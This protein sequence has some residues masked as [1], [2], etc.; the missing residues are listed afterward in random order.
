MSDF[1]KT[2]TRKNSLRKQCQ[3]LEVAD[4]EKIVA[5]LATIIDEKVQQELAV[6][7]EAEEKAAKIDE[8]RKSLDAAGLDLSDLMAIPEL[9]SKKKVAAKYRLTDESG[10]VHEWS[11]RGR[12]PLVFQKFFDEGNSK[13]DCLID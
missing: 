1:I 10:Q 9:S 13:E 5:D 3:E 4:L 8:I 11:G 2:L 7:K 6:E 12:T